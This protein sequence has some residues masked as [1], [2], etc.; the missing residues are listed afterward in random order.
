MSK[1]KFSILNLNKYPIS[2]EFGIYRLYKIPFNERIFENADKL[3][4]VVPKTIKETKKISYKSKSVKSFDNEKINIYIFEPKKIN[5][6]KVVLYIH[7]G[8]FVYRGAKHHYDFCKKLAEEGICKVV[9]VDYR[10]AYKYKYPVPIEDAFA[11]YKYILKKEKNKKIIVCG[12][13]AG[14]CLAID[15]IRKAK[16]LNMNIPD[17]LLLLY[18]VLDKRMITESMKKFTDTPVWNSVLNKKMWDLYLDGNNDYIS[19][20]EIGDVSFMPSTYIETAEY[21]CLHD[22]SIEF[23]EKL[24]KEHINVILNETKKTMHGFDMKNGKI[25]RKAVNERMELIKRI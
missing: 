24:K 5:T 25:T 11:A 21:D 10:L 6:T 17:Y 14:G 12:D 19:P 16:E 18:P 8:G 3:M 1:K 7:G 23:A 2:N 20:G 15:V 22:E 13:S 4:S 9:Y